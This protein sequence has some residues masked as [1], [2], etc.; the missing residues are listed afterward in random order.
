MDGNRLKSHDCQVPVD[1]SK[2]STSG[3]GSSR[4]FEY[5]RDLI[6][7]TFVQLSAAPVGHRSFAGEIEH[8]R[9]SGLE[10][11]TVRAGAQRVRR[12]PRLISRSS[13]AYLLASIQTAGRGL[14]IQDGRS[15]AL[16]PGTMAFYDSTR[17]YTLHFD[18]AFEQIVVQVPL[19]EALAMAGARCPYEATARLLGRDGVGGVVADFFCSLTAAQ[20]RD[21]AGAD[22]LA[23]A[24][25]L[26][27][28]SALSLVG[29]GKA[30]QNDDLRVRR[31][32]VISYLR[33][34][35]TDPSLNADAIAVALHLSRRTLFRVFAGDEDGVMGLLRRMRIEHAQRLLRNAPIRPVRVVAA[36][37]GFAGEVQFHRTFRALTGSTPGEFRAR[38]PIDAES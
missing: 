22:D 5:R 1:V 31:E 15:A 24:A 21:P 11:S 32:Q 34:H 36:E 8:V 7:D 20:Q 6:C 18:D 28:A 29:G 4:A 19:D 16:V 14:V 2:C 23:D 10:V 25:G 17:P 12:T 26:L 38:T 13:E 33:R 3:V 30:S 37:C 27:F 9:F 35:L